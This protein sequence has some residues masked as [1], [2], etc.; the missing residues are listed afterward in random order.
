MH[1]IAAAVVM[2]ADS[3]THQPAF[4]HP[5]LRHIQA[6]VKVRKKLARKDVAVAD[7]A[8]MAALEQLLRQKGG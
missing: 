3:L 5:G 2:A 1:R 4:P 6:C 7:A 8:V